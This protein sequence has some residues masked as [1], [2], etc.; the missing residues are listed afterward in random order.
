MPDLPVTGRSG[1][2]VR[3]DS[4]NTLVSELNLILVGPPGAGKGTQAEKLTE[5]FGLPYFATGNILRA[6]VAD[7]TELGRKAK[8]FMDAGELV[9]D[10]LIVGVLLEALD[11]EVASDGFL[12]D[13]F[14]RKVSQADALAEALEKVGRKLSGVLLI[15]VPDDEVIRRLSGRR[16]CVKSGHTY[17]VDFDPPKHEGVCDQDGSRLVQRDDDRPDT[18]RTRLATY[19]RD[20]EPLV[21]YYERRDLLRRF[22]GTRTPTEVHDHIR[23]TVATLRLEDEL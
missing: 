2:S 19:H 21:E 20:T 15:E 22:D 8:E 1:R 9:P 16:T 7:G 6:A 23:A 10:E 5:D 13:G 18:I 12:L 3:K 14:P 17:H 11:G 4:L